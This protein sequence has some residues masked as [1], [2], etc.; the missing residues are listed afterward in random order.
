MAEPFA[1]IP[2]SK[3]Q[4]DNSSHSHGFPS[5][6]IRTQKQMNYAELISPLHF[7]KTQGLNRPKVDS[8]AA[9]LGLIGAT[10]SYVPALFPIW[11]NP[12]TFSWEPYYEHTIAPSLETS[13]WIDYEF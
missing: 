12:Q 3:T 2:T 5:L 8:F 13:W 11:G 10:C 1:P 7:Q 4:A 6:F 9:A